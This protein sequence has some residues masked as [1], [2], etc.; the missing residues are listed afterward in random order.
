MTKKL[1]H[2]IRS[3]LL[4][5]RSGEEEYRVESPFPGFT[6]RVFKDKYFSDYYLKLLKLDH[7]KGRWLYSLNGARMSTAYDSPEEAARACE[8]HANTHLLKAVAVFGGLEAMRA[9]G[10]R[11]RDR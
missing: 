9:M 7:Q 11:I 6:M 10:K 3:V 4:W 5:H 1:P 8:V 2:K